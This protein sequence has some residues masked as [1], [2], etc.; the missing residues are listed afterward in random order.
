MLPSN[1]QAIPPIAIVPLAN[2]NAI[3]CVGIPF[4]SNKQNKTKENKTKQNEIKLTLLPLDP[5]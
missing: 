2:A 5:A 3:A 4:S 1:S